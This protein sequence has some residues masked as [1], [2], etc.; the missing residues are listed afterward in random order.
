[1]TFDLARGGP[2]RRSACLRANRILRRSRLLRTK[3]VGFTDQPD[4]INGAVRVETG[5]PLAELRRWLKSVENDLDRKRDG[6]PCGPR[7]IDLDVLV[8]N[9]EVLDQD[10]F[11]RPYLKE[12]VLDVWPGLPPE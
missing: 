9:G 8:W 3:P 11:K 6:H 7:T 10:F 2:S 4:F 5:M 12:N 1:M